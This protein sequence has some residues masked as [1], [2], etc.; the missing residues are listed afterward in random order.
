MDDG[1]VRQPP[2]SCAVSFPDGIVFAQLLSAALSPELARF[3][4]SYIR[5]SPLHSLIFP[6]TQA[7][8]GY[9]MQK[10]FF[11]LTPQ[12]DSAG[13][14]PSF[15]PSWFCCRACSIDAEAEPPSTSPKCG[16]IPVPCLFHP[17]LPRIF[18][19]SGTL[20]CL[21]HVSEVLDRNFLDIGARPSCVPAESSQLRS[22][23]STFLSRCPPRWYK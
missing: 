19:S 20:R 5:T 15:F 22:R 10:L 17:V 9:E 18:L 2:R 3:L 4:F 11:L 12:C 16:S 6:W 13:G 14:I 1:F 23:I 7:C 8:G 21:P